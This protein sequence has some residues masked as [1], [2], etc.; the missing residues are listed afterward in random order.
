MKY[1]ITHITAYH[2]SE[3][4]SLSQNELYLHPRQTDAQHVVESNLVIEPEPQYLHRR[5]DYFG[6][7]ARVFMV[8]QPH[9]ELTMSATS[10]VE[11][12]QIIT[13]LG[14]ALS[15]FSLT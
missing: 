7:I 13:M 2:Y 3:P 11:T 6:N 5:I 9:N 8:Q 12:K 4:A 14:N 10:I 15:F 1:R